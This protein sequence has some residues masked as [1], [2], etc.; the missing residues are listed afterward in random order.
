MMSSPHFM[1]KA[2]PIAEALSSLWK[3]VSVACLAGMASGTVLAETYPVGGTQQFLNTSAAGMAVGSGVTAGTWTG[4]SQYTT[5]SVGIIDLGV[6]QG[7]D[8]VLHLPTPDSSS[9][10]TPGAG[11]GGYVI[12][13]V[14]GDGSGAT[15]VVNGE[16]GVVMKAYRDGGTVA[17]YL[18]LLP[19]GTAISGDLMVLKANGDIDATLTA[20][21]IKNLTGL[22][23]TNGKIDSSSL[24]VPATTSMSGGT[25]SGTTTNSGTISGGTVSA[26]LAGSTNTGTINNA[27][28]TISGGTF[29]GGNL[30]ATTLTGNITGN[31]QSIT[32]LSTIGAT[33][34]NIT[35]INS[36]TINNSGAITG[37]TLQTTGG[38]ASMN[39]STITA[40]NNGNA[41]TVNVTNAS[42][43]T[44]V[45]LDG[46]N[47]NVTANGG[48][49]SGTIHLGDS[50]SGANNAQIGG[51]LTV[52]GTTNLNGATNNIGTTQVSTNIIGNTTSGTVSSMKGGNA[53][54]S[55]QNNQ[56][57]M[58]VGSNG[59]AVTNAGTTVTGT[60]NTNGIANTGTI[61]STGN[62]TA[63]NNITLNAATGNIAA[64]SLNTT[65]TANVGGDFSVNTDKFTVSAAT[66]NTA[67]GGNL[68]VTGAT[69]LT[70]LLTANG[71]GAVNGGFSAYSGTA[72]GNNL[73]VDG[74]SSRLVSANGS[75]SVA[76]SNS[77]NVVTGPT[78]VTGVTNINT[79]GTAATNI[80]N[81]TAATTVNLTG[82]ASS[83]AVSNANIALTN[84]TGSASIANNAVSMGVTNG[85]S[86][87]ANAA[88]ATIQANGGVST[89]TAPLT[90]GY[91]AYTAS[92]NL[93]AYNAANPAKPQIADT[94]LYNS[95]AN[96]TI[97]TSSP[98]NYTYTNKIEGNTLVNGDVY[99][100]GKLDY[101][102][103]SS[104]STTVKSASGN[105]T[106]L[107]SADQTAPN[108]L[109]GTKVT[110]SLQIVAKGA[111]DAS[112]NTAAQASA[113]LTLTNGI[114][115][116]HGI[117]IYENKTVLSG[118]T[119]STTMTL[120]D[121]DVTV[122]NAQTG[123]PVQI[124]GVADGTSTYDAVNF[125]QLKGLETKLSQ[126]IASTTAMTNIPQVDQNKTTSIGVGLGG[127]NGESAIAIGAG[128]R[129]A[130]NGVVKV[131]VASSNHGTPSYGMGAAWSW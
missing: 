29:S 78:T 33:T 97:N 103:N 91:S 1:P 31:S 58:T 82:G 40:G 17:S 122:A 94:L 61:S 10:L 66:G 75:N 59:V 129:F 55:V 83:V 74:T 27:G 39:G 71:G 22:T 64:T 3:P 54:V 20:A 34:G 13:S 47:G 125:G 119:H 21:N 63:G 68:N 43:N 98:K 23:F 69:T 111:A 36:T 79:T 9:G 62:I 14:E 114:G 73:F 26:N 105:G 45:S 44:T 116:T 4:T 49:T 53:T 99:I 11:Y 120:N 48:F 117:Q 106:I 88:S 84:G 126:G 107:S 35:T 95:N 70:G 101:V 121:N 57:N 104:A 86:F 90:N 60:L 51:N 8:A 19:S 24:N 115:N 67:V 30:G 6:A 112:G 37:G 50:T 25:L 38:A 18:K 87:S 72:T 15:L 80:G 110:G 92:Q 128:Y 5:T 46:A 131:S 56:A 42:G 118:G 81:N 89:G 32:G 7:Q 113:G 123:A 96:G 109:D 85:G 93:S 77:G 102:S 100:N 108:T 76:V 28:G 12:Q 130:Q 41:G 127:Y 16:G 124:K 2:K 65:G 52:S